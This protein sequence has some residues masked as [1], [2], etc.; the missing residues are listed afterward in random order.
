MT[1]PIDFESLR[2]AAR[3]VVTRAYAPYSGFRVGAAGISE[4]GHISTGCNV[5]NV[6]YGVGVCA[7]VGLVCAAVSGDHAPLLAVSVCDADGNLHALRPLPSVLLEVGGPDLFV[8]AVDGLAD[9]PN[10]CPTPSVRPISTA[11]IG[12]DDECGTRSGQRDRRQ[13]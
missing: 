6:S 3:D 12:G 4:S 10:C 9:C 1:Y 8:D 11:S 5:E 7:E 2:S 13:A